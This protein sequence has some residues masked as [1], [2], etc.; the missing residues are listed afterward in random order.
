ML[1]N[2]CYCVFNYPLKTQFNPFSFQKVSNNNVCKLLKNVN[3]TK[4]MGCALIQLKLS[5][6]RFP[7]PLSCIIN[8]A[9]S[10]SIFP[11]K[12]KKCF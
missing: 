3:V 9:I 6:Y 12:T 11:N 8:P 10:E 7:Y 5:T 2:N 4:A 1:Y